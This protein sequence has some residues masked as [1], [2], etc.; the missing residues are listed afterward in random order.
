M[1]F[2]L[3]VSG[4]ICFNLPEFYIDCPPGY[5][6]SKC[7]MKCDCHNK[8]T[9]EPHTGKCECAKGY[10]SEKCENIC[11]DGFYGA[12]CKEVCRCEN[13]GT[14]HHVSGECMCAPGFRGPL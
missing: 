14:C 3:N 4:V 9:C 10:T 12:G 1:F 6:G 2:V 5:W 11:M 7:E 8:A 13:G